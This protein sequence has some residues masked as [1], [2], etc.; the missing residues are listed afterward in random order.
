MLGAAEGAFVCPEGAA[1]LAAATRLAQE[2]WISPEEQVVLLNTGTGLKYPETV[3][4]TAPVLRPG[5][6]LPPG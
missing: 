3:P 5:D 1:T 6:S 4:V 2:A